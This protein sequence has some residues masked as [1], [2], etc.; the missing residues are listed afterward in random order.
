LQNIF[1]K[2]A[3]ELDDRVMEHLSDIAQDAIA[4]G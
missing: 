4:L 2:D 3:K 1:Y